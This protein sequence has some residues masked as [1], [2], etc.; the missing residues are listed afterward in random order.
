MTALRKLLTIAVMTVTLFVAAFATSF[1]AMRV[2]FADEA[3]KPA[4]GG[5]DTHDA[6]ADEG[7]DPSKHFNFLGSPAE[8]YGKDTAGGK[9]GDGV[10]VDDG[11]TTPG[12]EEMSPPFIWLVL[13][14]LYDAFLRRGSYS[15]MTGQPRAMASSTGL[16][17]PS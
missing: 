3:E 14:F 13:N 6:R 1:F 9:F 10:T 12:E 17:K 11:V 2:A 5:H 16:P 7:H 15:A 4:A 8:H